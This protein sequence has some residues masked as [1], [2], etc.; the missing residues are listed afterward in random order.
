MVKGKKHLA[1]QF[2][3]S[4]ME[5]EPRIWRRI[6]VPST[7]NFWDLHVAIQDSM[8][9]LDYHLH[10]FRGRPKHKRAPIEI[11]L[12]PDEIYEDPDVPVVPGWEVQI[13]DIF[14]DPGQVMGYEYDFGDSW[15]HQVLFEGI[16]LREKGTAYP[17]CIGGERACPPEDCGSVR[18]YYRLLEILRDS[19]HDEYE[20]TIGWLKGHAKNYH[21]YEPD[22]F[23]LEGVRFDSPTKRWRMRQIAP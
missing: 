17:R 4:L 7:Y 21:P 23:D 10:A 15:Q 12:P 1:Y 5:I 9:W 2:Q 14:I 11:G 8:G 19:N 22:R 6:L 16:L 3:I 18:G 13:A 20:E